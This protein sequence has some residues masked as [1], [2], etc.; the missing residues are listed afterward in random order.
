MIGKDEIQEVIDTLE[1]GWLSKGPKVE[2]FE[3]AFAAWTG[4]KHAIALNSCT[5]ALFLAL[6]AK[7][8]GP[9]DEVI[10]SAVTFSSTANT[11]VHT[12]AVPVFVDIDPLTLNADPEKLRRPS[13][14]GQKRLY[15]FISPAS[16]VIWIRF[17]PL[18]KSISYLS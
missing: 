4:A 3:K 9:G 8:I 1:S 18:P 13:P 2:A 14:R 10:T 15:P 17:W 11:I 6:K 5:A 7:G 16:R 12:G